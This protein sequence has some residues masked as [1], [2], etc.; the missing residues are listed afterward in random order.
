VVQPPVVLWQCAA[1]EASAAVFA[2]AALVVVV[3]VVLVAPSPVVSVLQEP[4]AVVHP[5]PARLGA[6]AVS[7]LTA[8]LPVQPPDEV[9]GVDAGAVPVLVAVG[10]VVACGV[11]EVAWQPPAP[12]HSVEA[13]V[14]SALE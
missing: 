6:A 7:V 1:P 9:T 12:W 11:L 5:A 8:Q 4:A 13:W 10:S 14:R 2:A 3:V